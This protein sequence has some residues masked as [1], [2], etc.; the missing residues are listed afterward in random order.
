MALLYDREL[1]QEWKTKNQGHV[2]AT[3]DCPPTGCQNPI[4][5]N[6]KGFMALPGKLSPAL[7]LLY[8]QFCSYCKKQWID[9]SVGCPYSSCRILI[10]K[11]LRS[12]KVILQQPYKSHNCFCTAT[13]I[14]GSYGILG[15]PDGLH[16]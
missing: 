15:I 12:S 8:D 10:V 5:L 2:L 16:L 9:E 3:A 4:L 7:S 13:G 14:F 6:F 1:Y 11:S